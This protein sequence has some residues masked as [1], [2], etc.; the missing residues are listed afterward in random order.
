MIRKMLLIAGLSI[1]MLAGCSKERKD[2]SQTA[3]TAMQDIGD[4]ASKVEQTASNWTGKAGNMMT[5]M[6]T[7]VKNWAY[8]NDPD[9]DFG[10]IAIDQHKVGI[11]MH[12]MVLDNGDEQNVKN[13]ATKMKAADEKGIEE[14]KAILDKHETKADTK[15]DFKKVVEKSFTDAQLNMD[16]TMENKIDNG[17]DPDSVYLAMMIQHHKGELAIGKAYL[18]HG[19]DK[20]LKAHVQKMTP[21]LQS[22]IKQM[23]AALKNRPKNVASKK[24]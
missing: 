21:V 10:E 1:S 2:A 20:A 16:E 6:W 22:D 4:A 14:I 13:M 5:H 19:K 7:G 12:Q 15:L 17:A 9:K 3:D 23:Q 18:M 24:Y 8:T 11:D